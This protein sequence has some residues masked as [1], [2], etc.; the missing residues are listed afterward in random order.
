MQL[1]GD[2]LLSSNEE[3]RRSVAE[4]IA[5]HEWEW[6]ER[7]SSALD[8]VEQ[9]LR[10]HI[11]DA[12]APAGLFTTE[13]D[14]TRPSLVR[15]VS[16]LRREHTNFLE[17]ASALRSNVKAAAHAFC[18]NQHMAQLAGMLPEPAP[19]GRI[20]DLDT[21]RHAIENFIT[22]L[23]LHRD[24]EVDLSIESVTTDLGAGD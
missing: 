12:E 18:P 8:R 5:G 11:V 13:V 19:E 23:L 6:A 17:Q 7:V 15:Q 2:G 1:A 14:L 22:T 9:A 24:R 16:K 20:V 10:Q 3:L 4:E 21:I